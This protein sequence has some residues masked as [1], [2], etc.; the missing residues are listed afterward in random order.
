MSPNESIPA[1]QTWFGGRYRQPVLN[2]LGL[3]QS[4]TR[5][6]CGTYDHLAE[7]RGQATYRIS[8]RTSASISPLALD[9]SKSGELEASF[10]RITCWSRLLP[11]LH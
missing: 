10:E 4:A 6:W 9:V 8:G 11:A 1:R 2:R 5:I 3:C 7:Q